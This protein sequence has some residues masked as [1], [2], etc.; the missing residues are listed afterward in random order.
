[1]K[2]RSICRKMG[3]TWTMLVFQNISDHHT[4]VQLCRLGCS[5]FS[6]FGNG[7]FFSHTFVQKCK[8]YTNSCFFDIPVRKLLSPRIPYWKEPISQLVSLSSNRLL[9][10]PT[11]KLNLLP[12]SATNCDQIVSSTSFLIYRTQCYRLKVNGSQ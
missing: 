9:I 4:K 6:Q 1:M 3:I 10:C 12:H 11:T 2:I 5:N 8:T 7:F